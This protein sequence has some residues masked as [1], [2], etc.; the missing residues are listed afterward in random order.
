M[1]MTKRKMEPGGRSGRRSDPDFERQEREKPPKPE[2]LNRDPQ[3]GDPEDNDSDEQ[4]Q[5]DQ[6]G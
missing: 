2:E 6:Q 3:P 1:K 4:R 5:G